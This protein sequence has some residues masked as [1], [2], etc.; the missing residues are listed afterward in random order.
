M[1]GMARRLGSFARRSPRPS[2]AAPAPA[3]AARLDD[4]AA[5][6][7]AMAVWA[8]ARLLPASDFA[9]LRQAHAGR[10]AD[11]DVRGEWAMAAA[12]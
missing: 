7:R 9:A 1:S 12:D 8:L 5:V 6:V 11:P 2:A 3:A 4:P 10:E